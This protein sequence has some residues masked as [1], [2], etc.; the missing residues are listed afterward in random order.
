MKSIFIWSAGLFLTIFIGGFFVVLSDS[1]ENSQAFDPVTFDLTD[2][3]PYGTF[4]KDSE[5]IFYVPAR[6]WVSFPTWSGNFSSKYNKVQVGY[7]SFTTDAANFG[8]SDL[9]TIKQKITI[10]VQKYPSRRDEYDKVMFELEGQIPDEIVSGVEIYPPA[11]EDQ[12]DGSRTI[13]YKFQGFDNQNVVGFCNDC[14]PFNE[15]RTVY[16]SIVR[17]INSGVSVQYNFSTNRISDLYDID[18]KVVEYLK[19][20][21]VPPSSFTRLE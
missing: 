10:W 3:K 20:L 1:R 18:K 7:F 2:Y 13:K 17:K 4:K 19:S 8:E 5:N 21:Q 14:T 11:N 6:H 9:Y 12:I 16:L 15:S